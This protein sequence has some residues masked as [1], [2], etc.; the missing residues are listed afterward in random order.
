MVCM[1]NDE[2][3]SHAYHSPWKSLQ[4][5][6]QSHRHD[7]DGD[8]YLLKTAQLWDTHS[9]GNITQRH[10]VDSVRVAGERVG[11]SARLQIPHL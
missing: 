11:F 10:T 9:E 1:E 6:P 8:E 5:F 7:Y 2:A 4:R 3:V